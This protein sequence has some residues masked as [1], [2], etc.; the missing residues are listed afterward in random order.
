[1]GE[2][3][4]PEETRARVLQ[5]VTSTARRGAEVFATQLGDALTERRWPVETVALWPG[6][7]SATLDLA[8]LGRRRRDPTALRALRARRRAAGVVVGHGSST[9]PFG[10]IATAS[11]RRGPT[12]RVP[13]VYRSIGDPS[14]WGSSRAR[15]ARV[16]AALRRAT[17]VVAL[18]PGAADIIAAR[19]GI[20]RERI[21]VIPTGV[22]ADG[23]APAS[24]DR[25]A[26]ARS[27][28]AA[29]RVPGLDP[30]L[31]TIVL[32]GALSAEKNPLAAIDA[33]ASLADAQ[34]LVAGDGPLAAECAERGRQMAPGRVHL[35]GPV[36]DPAEVLA[37]A[38]LLVL[39][40]LTEGIPAVAIEA[41]LAGLPVVAARVGG[42][43]EV[44]VDGE[45]GVLL[46]DPTPFRLARAVERALGDGAVLGAAGRDR[47]L[48]RFTLDVVADAWA[49]L[50]R[51]V[52]AARSGGPDPSR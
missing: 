17:A 37:A 35:L 23:L 22:P 32:L 20:D 11:A 42:I 41:G 3:P 52:V 21:H 39:P 26:E 10:A 12:D 45:T 36:A 14:F 9:L 48:D 24:P 38:D 43:P 25:R 15:R 27:V 28:L 16:G 47:A 7:G 19:Y 33:M 18:W 34:L 29:G 31:P 4:E 49:E 1:M 46:D 8:V 50:L 40:S 6:A 2:S 13:F 44:V 51:S 30:D 5:V